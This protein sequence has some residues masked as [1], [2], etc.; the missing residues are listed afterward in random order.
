MAFY[1]I[2]HLY[3]VKCVSEIEIQFRDAFMLRLRDALKLATYY[4]CVQL[5]NFMPVWYM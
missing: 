1:I 3:S 2:V 4:L 5:H